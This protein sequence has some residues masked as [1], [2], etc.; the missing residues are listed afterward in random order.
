LCCPAAKDVLNLFINSPDI[1]F[2]PDNASARRKLQM[3]L[4]SVSLSLSIAI[5]L[6]CAQ[7]KASEEKTILS[8]SAGRK[9]GVSSE[10]SAGTPGT[11]APVGSPA[12]RH[13]FPVMDEKG[14]LLTCVA[15]QMDANRDTDDFKNCVLAPGRT[16]DDVMHSFIRAAHQQQ[17]ELDAVKAAMHTH[18]DDKAETNNASK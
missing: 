14:L 4:Y 16:L 9:P 13:V 17:L 18:A 15:P 2:T 12:A 6:L 1:G 10:M 5:A 11:L 8:A 7:A 3:K